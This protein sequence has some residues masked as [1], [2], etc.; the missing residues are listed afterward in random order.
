MENPPTKR[1]GMEEGIVLRHFICVRKSDQRVG[2]NTRKGV[3]SMPKQFPLFIHFK[4]KN[5]FEIAC[6]WKG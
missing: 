2:R 6:Q 5:A 1:G 4:I 3:L